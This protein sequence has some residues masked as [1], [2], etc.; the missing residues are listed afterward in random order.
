[1]KA[2]I[3]DL[4]GTLFQTEKV[5]V[6]A[7]QET[8]RHLQT[9][10]RFQGDIP[11]EA[12][13]Q[14]VFGL[15][16][17]ELWE[18]L[19]PG[20]DRAVKEEADRFML[21]KELELFR[22]GKGEIFPRVRETLMQFYEDGWPLFVASNGVGDYVRTALETK[23]LISLFKGIYTAGEYQTADKS[24]LVR[25]LKND[26]GVTDGWMVGDRSSDIK[27]GK[28]NQLFAVGCRYTGYPCFGQENELDEA[29]AIIHSFPELKQVVEALKK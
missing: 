28:E 21:Q 2:I 17:Q 19:L 14:S 18:V 16:H 27:A 6:P 10:G 3:F 23:G 4:D 26:H 12:N 13:I 29:D 1:M 22:L 8:F 24:D 9:T 5:A 7:F 20:A 15:T 11:D 25:I